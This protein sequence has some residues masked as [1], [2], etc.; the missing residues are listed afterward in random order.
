MLQIFLQWIKNYSALWYFS[1][2]SARWILSLEKY[3]IHC[4]YTVYLY[5]INPCSKLRKQSIKF[6]K[7]WIY[8]WD[9]FQII[10][11]HDLF[12]TNRVWHW[13][14]WIDYLFWP[15]W[16]ARLV[17]RHSTLSSNWL[18]LCT[19][20]SNIH[21][22]GFSYSPTLICEGFVHFINWYLFILLDFQIGRLSLTPLHGIQ[23]CK[24]D[25]ISDTSHNTP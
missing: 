24:A 2:T 12:K 4:I 11:R 21:S 1:L 8:Q 25:Q 9:D 14:F 10:G 22:S 20:V 18:L 23:I 7:S 5:Y 15:H 16:L 13:L 17:V 6:K 3:S 19:C